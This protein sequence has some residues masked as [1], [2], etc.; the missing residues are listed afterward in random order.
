MPP[1]DPP[2][3]PPDDDSDEKGQV[4][5]IHV[6][7]AIRREC[8]VSLFL[9]DLSKERPPNYTK[10]LIAAFA[11]QRSLFYDMSVERIMNEFVGGYSTKNKKYVEAAVVS[12]LCN[13]NMHM[14]R[15]ESLKYCSQLKSKYH[16]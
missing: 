12:A 3:T 1:L 6:G 7:R 8:N 5:V 13:L 2:T 4:G 9:I 16:L 10:F 15:L 11:Q 14:K